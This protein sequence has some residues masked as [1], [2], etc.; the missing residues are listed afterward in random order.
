MAALRARLGSRFLTAHAFLQRARGKAFSVLA[1]GG[2]AA[3][4]HGTVIQLP[5][6]LDGARRIALGDGVFVGAG[7]WLHVE[8][9]GEH[10]VLEVGDGTSI[11]GDCVLSAVCEVR[12]GRR[13]LLARNVYIADHG[14]AF[15]DLDR[16]VLDQGL[17]RIAPVRIGDGAWL[18]QNV[19]VCPGVTIGA[20]AV[21]GANSVVT[22]DVPAGAVAAG[23]PARLLREGEPSLIKAAP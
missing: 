1:S 5:V 8:G 14:H 16:A 2:F 9:A 4:G 21:V 17:D 11:V 18:G 10:V 20:G 15:A 23:V 22:R 12:L 13:V 19:V 7:S 6:R 3:F